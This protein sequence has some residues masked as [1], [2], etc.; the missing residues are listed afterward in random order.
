MQAAP[1]ILEIYYIEYFTIVFLNIHN[2]MY[3]IPFCKSSH[4]FYLA[5]TNMADLNLV[6]DGPMLHVQ[7]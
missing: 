7:M 1:I 4:I 5:K 2:C 3:K 6:D